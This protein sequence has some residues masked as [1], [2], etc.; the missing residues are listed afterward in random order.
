MHPAEFYW[1]AE[2][3]DEQRNAQKRESGGITE[4]EAL[5]MKDELRRAR[6]NAGY[7]AD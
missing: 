5:E 6:V 1:Y 4:E 7:T 3:K 2:A